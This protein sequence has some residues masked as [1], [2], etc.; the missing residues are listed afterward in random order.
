LQLNLRLPAFFSGFETRGFLI[1]DFLLYKLQK[2]NQLYQNNKIKI[3]FIS[4]KI[5][6]FNKYFE[7]KKAA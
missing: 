3:L 5:S 1:F 2:K 4:L 7:N 6:I